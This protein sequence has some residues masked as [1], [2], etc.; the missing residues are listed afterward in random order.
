MFQFFVSPITGREFSIRYILNII[1]GCKH[2][3]H[4][5]KVSMTSHCFQYKVHTLQ[6]LSC[7]IFSHFSI[8]CFN[9][10]EVLRASHCLILIYVSLLLYTMLLMP[11]TAPPPHFLPS[12]LLLILKNLTQA[13]AFF[14]SLCALSLLSLSCNLGSLSFSILELLSP[15]LYFSYYIIP[16]AFIVLLFRERKQIL[17]TSSICNKTHGGGLNK[18]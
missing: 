16:S 15:L 1:H 8:L 3:P 6:H 17:F 10:K 4:I 18:Y 5:L 2:V 14:G 12:E 13:S 7:I 9:N 11:R